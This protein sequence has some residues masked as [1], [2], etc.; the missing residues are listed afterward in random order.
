MAALLAQEQMQLTNRRFEVALA[1][2][3]AAAVAELYTFDGQVLAPNLRAVTGRQAIERIWQVM[4]QMGVQRV[5]LMTLEVE[6]CC[7]ELAY[8]L[9]RAILRNETGAVVDTLKYMVI[10]KQEAGQWKWHRSIWN[11]DAAASPCAV[12]PTHLRD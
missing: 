12:H 3:D 1:R 2:M 7:H 8:E 11:S 4:I 5:V 10:W 6:L 9:G